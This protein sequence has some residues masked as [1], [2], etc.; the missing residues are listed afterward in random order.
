MSRLRLLSAAALLTIATGASASSFVATTD[1]VGRAVVATT[2]T[3]S[4]LSSSLKDDKIFRAARDDAASF[5]ASQGAIRGAQLEAALRHIR[6]Q[7]PHLAAS[8]G[9]LA[10]A[11]LAL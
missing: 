7:A 8:D 3:S 6:Q 4:D 9:Q 10:E 11:I 1:V 5:V 2:D